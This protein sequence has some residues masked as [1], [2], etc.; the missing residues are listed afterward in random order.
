MEPREG[1]NLFWHSLFLSFQGE[2]QVGMRE[3]LLTV[4]R[5]P[6]QT[7]GFDGKASNSW[8]REAKSSWVYSFWQVKKHAFPPDLMSY[9][10]F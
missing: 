2:G 7:P 6:L 5:R 3:S 9:A 10:Q 1:E 8:S 4:P